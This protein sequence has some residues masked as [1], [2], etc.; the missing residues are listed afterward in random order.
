MSVKNL[1]SSNLYKLLTFKTIFSISCKLLTKNSIYMRKYFLF[2]LKGNFQEN[3]GKMFCINQ[4]HYREVVMGDFYGTGIEIWAGFLPSLASK[5]F[6]LWNHLYTS[7]EMIQFVTRFDLSKIYEIFSIVS[8][9]IRD[10]S[11][12]DFSIMTLATAWYADTQ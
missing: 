6:D 4:R 10:T 2:W 9:S 3:K 12:R 7:N 11:P 8:C 1:K 5:T